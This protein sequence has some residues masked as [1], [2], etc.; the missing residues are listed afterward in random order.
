MSKINI[1]VPS[2]SAVVAPVSISGTT[3]RSTTL[4]S[5]IARL[6][7]TVDCFAVFGNSSVVATTSGHF[8]GAGKVYD[9]AYDGTNVAFIT[10]GGTG[11]VYISELN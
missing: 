2:F 6:Q 3:A 1:T 4:S 7:P 8:L 10:S 9:I 11:S 5:G